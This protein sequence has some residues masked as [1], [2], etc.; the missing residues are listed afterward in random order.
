MIAEGPVGIPLSHAGV[1]II[2]EN[3]DAQSL[4]LGYTRL[5]RY[6]GLDVDGLGIYKVIHLGTFMYHI[7]TR[8]VKMHRN[9][10]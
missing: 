8:P 7:D 4:H 6:M 3:P 5:Y 1:S 2:P 9:V 10:Q